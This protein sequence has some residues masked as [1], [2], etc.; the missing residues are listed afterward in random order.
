MV[1]SSRQALRSLGIGIVMMGFGCGGQSQG[2]VA[3]SA[4]AGDAGGDSMDGPEASPSDAGSEADA[5][6]LID[7]PANGPCV[8]VSA[9]PAPVGELPYGRMF[10]SGPGELWSVS[11]STPYPDGGTFLWT[12]GANWT[13]LDL[14]GSSGVWAFAGAAALATLDDAPA[15]GSTTKLPSH[16]DLS[17]SESCSSWFLAES[18]GMPWVGENGAC[19]RTR[20]RAELIYPA[21]AKLRSIPTNAEGVA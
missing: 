6:T 15:F 10:F 17:A 3:S 8:R 2:E 14:P 7:P 20:A 11:G 1:A 4:D 5:P 9:L 19:W 18:L 12:E 13:L 16:E 21:G